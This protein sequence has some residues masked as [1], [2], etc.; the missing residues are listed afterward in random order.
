MYM[1]FD[2]FILFVYMFCRYI[3]ICEIIYYIEKRLEII[4][5]VIMCGVKIN[6]IK[7]IKKVWL[8]ICSLYIYIEWVLKYIVKWIKLNVIYTLE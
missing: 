4:Y 2:F 1:R 5:N 6:K 7:K 8:Y 3:Y